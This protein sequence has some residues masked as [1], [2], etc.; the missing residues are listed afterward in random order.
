M[1]YSDAIGSPMYTIGRTIQISERGGKGVS[2]SEATA[3]VDLFKAKSTLPTSR[4]PA[5]ACTCQ[6]I[7]WKKKKMGRTMLR[8]SK[9]MRISLHTLVFP[10]L[11]SFGIFNA[12]SRV[13]CDKV[14]VEFA[15]IGSGEGRWDAEE[16]GEPD[17]E[18]EFLVE[19]AL[20]KSVHELAVV[21]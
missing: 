8:Q 7:D 4:T 1:P 2:H 19:T 17:S 18:V 9:R 15:Q 5:H 13:N 20:E 3:T 11:T 21:S 10:P 12:N 16:V 6:V 14:S